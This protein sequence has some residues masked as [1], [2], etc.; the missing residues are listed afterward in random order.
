MH[1]PTFLCGNGLGI[2]PIISTLRPTKIPTRD[3]RR[4]RGFASA[5]ESKASRAP[6]LFALNKRISHLVGTGRLGEARAVFD[7]AGCRNTAAWNA[8]ITGY[9]KRGEMAKARELFDG[10][11]ERDVMSWNLMISDY[12]SC[13][14][15]RFADEGR[16]LFEQ[17]P[18]REYIVGMRRLG[19]WM[20]RCGY[21]TACLREMLFL[22][23]RW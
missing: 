11:P 8:M 9:A 10:M 15:S 21:L 3:S 19:G 17:M 1:R 6:D 22:G 5:R 4:A 16:N 14:G 23:I 13:R 20:R 7:I 12:I 18:E 2:D